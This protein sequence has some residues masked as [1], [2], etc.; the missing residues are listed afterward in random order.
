MIDATPVVALPI[1]A[2]DDAND[3]RCEAEEDCEDFND[4]NCDS[5][6]AAGEVWGVWEG[7]DRRSGVLIVGV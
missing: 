3:E 6:A 2:Y 4:H 7:E 1:A 5:D